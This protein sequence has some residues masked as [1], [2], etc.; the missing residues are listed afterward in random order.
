MNLVQRRV[1]VRLGAEQLRERDFAECVV[2]D[3]VQLDD[4]RA[5]AAVAGVHTRIKHARVALAMR[6]RR[7]PFQNPD[8]LIEMNLR[9]RSR[10][11][12]AGRPL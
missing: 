7:L 11:R 8:D 9:C 10:E 4:D 6:F 5:N 12:V 3:L 1:D 2:D